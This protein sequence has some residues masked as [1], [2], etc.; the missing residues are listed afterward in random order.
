VARRLERCACDGA[1]EPEE[2][3]EASSLRSNFTKES[4][5][6]AVRR[7][8]DY[9]A[10]GDIYQVNLAQRFV[11]PGAGDPRAFFARWL[12]WHRM[13]YAAFVDGGSWSLVSNSP[14]C[15]LRRDGDEVATLPIKGTRP[16][17]STCEEDAILRAELMDSPKDRAEHLMIVDLERN[18]LGRVCKWGS[19]TAPLRPSLRSFPSVH[20]LESRVVGRL[21]PDISWSDLLRALFPGGSITGAPKV[22]AMEIIDEIEP[23]ARRF[24]TGSI[25]FIDSAQWAR[26]NVAIRTAIATE[27]S[28]AYHTGGGIVADSTPDLE[29]EETLLKA[30]GFLAALRKE[31]R[32]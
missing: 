9:I 1:E 20:H 17:G 25:G 28:I 32:A 5:L 8:L 3:P 26:L 11:A 10:A 22:R 31:E 6:R 23:V 7:A 2:G 27:E 21:R 14:E 16:R 12:R 15:L 30:R 29:Y 19:V 24:Y 4:Y 18:D 13:P